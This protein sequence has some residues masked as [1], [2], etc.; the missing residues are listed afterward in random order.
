MPKP[1]FRELSPSEGNRARCRPKLRFK[2]LCE[3]T[4]TDF[5]IKPHLWIE[6]AAMRKGEAEFERVDGRQTIKKKRLAEENLTNPVTLSDCL[7]R[8]KE[9]YI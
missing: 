5:K 2:D 9:P 8:R 7:Q 3:K 4:M 6:M 1:F